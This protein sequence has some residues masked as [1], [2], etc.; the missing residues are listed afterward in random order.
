ML[1]KESFAVR[2]HR[3]FYAEEVPYGLALCRICLPLVLMGLV[4]PRWVVCR[5]LYSADGATGQLSVGY[6]YIDLLPELSGNMVAAL[7]TTMIFAM[8]SLCVGWCTRISAFISCVLLTYFCMLD[9]VSTMTKYTA[10]S[11]H[12]LLILSM[13]Q[14]G[15]IWSVDAWLASQKR[16]LDPT[17][18]RVELPKSA[19]WP[20]RLIQL[21][22]AWVYFGA[23][24]TKIHTPSFFT[25]DQLQYWML[26]HLNYKHPLGELLSLYPILLV[27]AGFVTVV[28][29][30]TFIFCSWKSSWRNIILPIGISFHFMT[31][32]TL[33]LLMFPMVCYCTY[34][35]FFDDED[36]SQSCAWM[37]RKV[38]QNAWL[39]AFQQQLAV[40]RQQW[41]QHPEWAAK[42]RWGF[43]V[44]VPVVALI[45]LQLERY[46]DLY[47]ER[48]PEGR[49][50]LTALD[51]ERAELMLA[52]AAPQRDIDKFFS[53]DMGTFLIS[54]LLA[55]RRTKFRQGE[56]MIAQCN[57]A[58]PHPDMSVEC[59]I[60][61]SE[62]RLIER[63]PA[64]ATREMF[65]VN[66]TFPIS[67]TMRPGE[68]S[69]IIETAGR[70][71]MQKKFE[72]LPKYG[73]VA[74]R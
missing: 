34:F 69:M 17:K 61:D 58:P 7:Y 73:T 18:P 5:E 31:A 39:K 48:R 71:V 36:M 38:R 72:V 9:C 49:Y 54:D 60:R 10:I 62:N 24:M 74:A 57:L 55:D 26:T 37:R 21:H 35:A 56:K 47:G 66:I 14:C 8:L 67:E 11:S 6:G 64:I 43:A 30:I 32:L 45:G 63:I 70:H 12:V 16:N 59:K 15:A 4:L 19:A 52:P 46:I 44:A 40:W 33:G 28:W 68:Y 41:G 2:V 22:I 23:G 50:Q 3:F 27:T 51:P 42:S 53:V 25:G 29:E 1:Q 65:R 13:S 20:R